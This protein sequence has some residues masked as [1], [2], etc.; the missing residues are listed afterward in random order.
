MQEILDMYDLHQHINIQHTNWEIHSIGCISIHVQKLSRTLPAKTFYRTTVSSS[1]HFR[2]ARKLLQMQTIRRDLSK[3]NE[4]SF[5]SN[6]KN[7]LEVETEKTL[8]QNYNNYRDAIK[9]TIDKHAPLKTKTKTKKDQNPWSDRDAQRLKTQRRLAERRWIKSKQHHD[10]IEYKHINAIYKKHLHHSKKMHILIKL[11]DTKNKAKN[12]YRILRSLTKPKDANPMPSTKSPSDLPDKFA[13]FFLNKI[14]KIREQ[15]HDTDTVKTYHRKCTGFNSFLP[16]DREEILNIIKK[17]NPTTSIM[18]P[19]N[20]RFLLK[21]K[22]TIADA[23][24]TIT[25]QSLTTR[26]FLEDWK[27][28][29]V[30]PLIKGQ[31]ISTELKN[32]RPI[33]NLSFL[34]KVIEK[35]VQAQLQK[36]FGKPSLLPNHQ[37]AYRQHHSTETT[38]LNMCDNILKHG[39]CTSM[40]CL[41]LSAAFDTVNHKILLGIL[42]SYFG[43]SDHALDWIFSYPSKRNFLVQ[44]GQFTSKTIEIDFSFPQGSILGPILFNCYASALMEDIPECKESFL[45]GYADD[46]TMIHYFSPDNKSTKQ[47]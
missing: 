1:G 14:R 44:I 3:I 24:T 17:M 21:F 7:N 25:N 36:H 37:S 41:D 6:L 28:A 30:R 4:E 31:N 43:N 8:Q 46:H 27:V 16:I 42:K 45:S 35:A 33:S 5:T 9:K 39:K 26:K 12:L 10:L 15:C 34:S 18:D 47:I 19:C 23:I 20:T 40:V 29:A 22:E 38:L 32:Y 13:D 11:N 2:S